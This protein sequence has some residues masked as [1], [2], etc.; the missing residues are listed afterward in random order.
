MAWCTSVDRAVRQRV[1]I[2][3]RLRMRARRRFQSPGSSAERVLPCHCLA[4]FAALTM[5]LVALPRPFSYIGV[6]SSTELKP[7]DPH[8]PAP[9]R[10]CQLTTLANDGTHCFLPLRDSPGADS[11]GLGLGHRSG[12]AN[13]S[14]LDTRSRNLSSQDARLR[15][16][17]DHSS[18]GRSS[19]RSCRFQY[20]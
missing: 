12:V 14:G 16:G 20:W 8:H 17:F 2:G 15:F 1:Q 4:I 7:V 19:L 6:T 13:L 10:W 18:S 9:R 11:T 3:S 5:G